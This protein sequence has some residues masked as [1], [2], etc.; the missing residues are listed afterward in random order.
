MIDNIPKFLINVI[1]EIESFLN[2]LGNRKKT[3]PVKQRTRGDNITFS[4]N[5]YGD[6]IEELKDHLVNLIEPKLTSI[7]GEI[8]KL[9]VNQGSINDS[10]TIE[11]EIV[12]GRTYEVYL[13]KQEAFLYIRIYQ[14]RRLD[15]KKNQ[16][17]NLLDNQWL[18]IDIDYVKRSAWFI[19]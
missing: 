9:L 15:I 12:D 13:Y 18:S 19:D 16:N 3:L 5:I 2:T 17:Y 7:E 14:E 10:G 6:N 11:F 1:N 8:I 4:W